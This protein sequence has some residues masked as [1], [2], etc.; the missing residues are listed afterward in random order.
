MNPDEIKRLVDQIYLEK[1]IDRAVI[2]R[3]I[4]EALM[5]AAK[6][7]GNDG[8]DSDYQISIDPQTGAIYAK[9]HAGTLEPVVVVIETTPRANII[10][11]YAGTFQLTERGEVTLDGT[12]IDGRALTFNAIADSEGVTMHERTAF[13]TD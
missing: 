11:R 13:I 5:T 4:E 9:H 12:S 3:C 2:F 8:D 6:R 10:K 1:G 7:H